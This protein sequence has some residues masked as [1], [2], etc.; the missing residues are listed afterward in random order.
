MSH[1]STSGKRT[2]PIELTPGRPPADAP[3]VRAIDTRALAFNAV[4]MTIGTTVYVVPALVAL[5]VGSAGVLAFI[6]CAL[7]MTLVVL[8]FAEAGSRV[9]RSGGTYAWAEVAFGPFVAFLVAWVFYFGAQVVGTASV[10]TLMLG[11]LRQLVPAL[12]GPWARAAI[13]ITLLGLVALVNIRGVRKSSRLVERVTTVKLLPL[14]LVLGASVAAISM[15]NLSI[16]TLPS[17]A[18][19]GRAV[20][21]VIFLFAGIEAALSA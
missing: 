12:G 4:N 15:R 19:F 13:V 9:S 16:D 5:E 18:S 7:L 1:E 6:A 10:V 20:L 21:L 2:A 17:A 8:C 14:V 3:L 11:A